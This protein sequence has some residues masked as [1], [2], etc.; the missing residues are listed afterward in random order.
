MKERIE[1]LR[2]SEEGGEEELFKIMNNTLMS[3]ADFLQDRGFLQGVSKLLRK[4]QRGY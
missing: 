3:L 1:K 2:V 4:L